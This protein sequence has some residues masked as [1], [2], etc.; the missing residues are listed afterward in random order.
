M[1]AKPY[2]RRYAPT[3]LKLTLIYLADNIVYTNRSF[4]IHTL[5]LVDSKCLGV[6]Y[7]YCNYSEAEKQSPTNLLKSILQQLVLRTGILVNEMTELYEKHSK[8]MTT[9]SLGECCQLLK[10]AAGCLPKVCIV[11]DALDECTE[12]T[13]D[14]LLSEIRQTM[15]RIHLFITSRHMF[16]HQCARE[17]SLCLEISADEM[18]IR[19]YLYERMK[20][21]RTLHAHIKKDKELHD[22]I[23]S[24]IVGKARG[25]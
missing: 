3:G 1:W 21:S 8:T 13:R 10:A 22:H 23:V 18:D 11:I 14:I 15:P 25:M 9:P 6:A 12:A 24:G 19:Q 2:L 16:S 17:D 4:I 7:L 5:Q 20:D